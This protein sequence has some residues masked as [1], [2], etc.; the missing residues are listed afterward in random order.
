MV[1]SAAGTHCNELSNVMEGVFTV[2][3]RYI[4]RRS[5]RESEKTRGHL[6]HSTIW[7][8]ETPNSSDPSE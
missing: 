6:I 3:T 8:R 4:G 2:S 5:R 1:R 7:G